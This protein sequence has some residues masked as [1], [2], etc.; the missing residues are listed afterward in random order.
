[1]FVYATL[2][3][4]AMFTAA[5]AKAASG[6]LAPGREATRFFVEVTADNARSGVLAD[7]LLRLD[8]DVLWKLLDY[9]TLFA[10]G[11]LVVAVFIPTL[12]RVGL[13]IL[14]LFHVGV[15]LFLGIDFHLHAFVYA[16]FFFVPKTYWL[17]EIDLL[18]ALV[19]AGQAEQHFD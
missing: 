15:W 12:F 5:A 7:W 2:I 3:A 16:G 14:S 4:F 10:E 13:V 8:S 6:W 11:W 9:A 18:R 1:M 19:V 17:R